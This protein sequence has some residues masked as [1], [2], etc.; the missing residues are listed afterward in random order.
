MHNEIWSLSACE[1][2][3]GIRNKRFSCIEV[4]ESVVA[5][6]RARNTSL[7]AIVNDQTAAALV[8]AKKADDLQASGARI[9]PLHGVPVTIK[10]NID[11]KGMP[12]P[13]GLPGLRNVI[14]SEDSP[15]VRNLR[16][17]GAIIVGQTNVPELSMR[18]TTD[19]PLHGRTVNPWNEWASPGGS[20]GGAGA[21]AAAGFGP[22]H[23]GNDIGGS[24]RFPAFACGVSSIKPTFGRIPAYTPTSGPEPGLLSQLTS[25]QGAICREVRDVRLAASVMAEGDPRDP[26]WVPVPFTGPAE[27]RPIKVAFIKEAHGYPIH[28]EIA[29]LLD[30][31]AGH[32]SNAGYAVEELSAP[33]IMQPAQAWFDI[34]VSEIEETLGPLARQFGSE[35]IQRIF[36]YYKRIGRVADCQGYRVGI[37]ERTALTREC[38]VFLEHYPLVLTPILM[39]P[40][41]PWDYDAR[42]FEETR[43]LLLAAIYSVGVNYLSLPAGVVPVGFVENLPAAV[44]IIGRRFREDL[45]LDAME[46]I[47]REAGVLS[48]KLWERERA[49]ILVEQHS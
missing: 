17:A 48:H 45:I 38:N 10:Q 18:A 28:S 7:N 21:A 24:L 46:A 11:V 40:L 30:R 37:A 31:A 6:I 4:M 29:N 23:H 5:R 9:G 2:A 19:N 35:T 32:L 26:W 34:L 1:I 15:V 33:S 12:T 20:S 13:N 25:V 44:Q 41:Y 3:Q 47:E 22:I 39:R 42:G 8:A 14:A 49:D 43:D 36:E 27:A 16:Q